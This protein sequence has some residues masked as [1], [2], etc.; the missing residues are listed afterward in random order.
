L[1][2]RPPH[3][4]PS[5]P[6][7]RRSA[8]RKGV[9]ALSHTAEGSHR[10]SRINGV[11]ACEAPTPRVDF[12]SSSLEP[13]GAAEF[14][15]SLLSS[16]VSQVVSNFESDHSLIQTRSVRGERATNARLTL[17]RS[18]V[19]RVASIRT[20]VLWLA[21]SRWNSLPSTVTCSPVTKG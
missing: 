9:K 17:Q 20:D 21:L 16:P 2:R 6:S 14:A 18:R 7:W 11:P 12:S 1:Q 8:I 5:W 19:T 15:S 4:L 10:G 13:V 3:V